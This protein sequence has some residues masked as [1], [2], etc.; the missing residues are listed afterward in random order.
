M[1]G[2]PRVPVIPSARR[3]GPLPS[4][5]LAGRSV[6]HHPGAHALGYPVLE[7]VPGQRP[8]QLGSSGMHLLQQASSAPV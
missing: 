7:Q 6:P 3:Q 1:H 5:V 8:V 4:V 2:A